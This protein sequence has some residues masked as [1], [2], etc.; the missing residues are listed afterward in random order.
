MIVSQ[1][2]VTLHI[3]LRGKVRLLKSGARRREWMPPSVFFGLCGGRETE[4]G[5]RVW[6]F[7]SI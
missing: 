6:I 7:Q 3:T 1:L 2:G 4:L 5:L